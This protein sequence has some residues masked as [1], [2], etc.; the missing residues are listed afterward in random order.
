MRAVLAGETVLDSRRGIVLRETGAF[1]AY[2]YPLEDIRQDLL[3]PSP[4][5]R[6]GGACGSAPA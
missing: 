5:P 2:Y 3:E 6:G 1:P 4:G